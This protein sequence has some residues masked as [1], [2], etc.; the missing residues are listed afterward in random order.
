[1]MMYTVTYLMTDR[2]LK[3]MSLGVLEVQQQ[4]VRFHCDVK[5]AITPYHSMSMMTF[6]DVTEMPSADQ[7]SLAGVPAVIVAEH[8]NPFDVTA[9]GKEAAIAA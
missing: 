3:A 2:H 1:M 5:P 7:L 9:V 6:I 4:P 8:I